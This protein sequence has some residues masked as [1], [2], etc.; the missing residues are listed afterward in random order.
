LGE[1]LPGD[2]PQIDNILYCLFQQPREGFR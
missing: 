1:V 2:G